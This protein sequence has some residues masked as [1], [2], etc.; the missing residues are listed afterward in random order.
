M[1][2]TLSSRQQDVVNSCHVV[3]GPP[4]PNLLTPSSP[5]LLTPDCCIDFT[6]NCYLDTTLMGVP[7]TCCRGAELAVATEMQWSQHSSVTQK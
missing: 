5:H 2:L 1:L 4:S 6:T 7:S 3:T